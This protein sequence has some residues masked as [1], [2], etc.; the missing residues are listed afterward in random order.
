M[1]YFINGKGSA[2]NGG[3][4]FN[5]L[6]QFVETK[7]NKPACNVVTKKNCLPNELTFIEKNEG[8]TAD[9][10]A[11]EIKTK[12][13]ALKAVKKERSDAEAALRKQ[14]AEWKKKEKLITKATAI[15][16]QLEKGAKSGAKKTPAPKPPPGADEL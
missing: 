10:L 7:L 1:G 4:D 14:E 5:S 2:Y 15:L 8:K 12:N 16:K 9:E 3:R 11:A 13:D 6:K